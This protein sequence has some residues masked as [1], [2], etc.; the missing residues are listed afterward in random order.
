MEKATTENTHDPLLIAIKLLI[1]ENGG[2]LTYAYELEK[3]WIKFQYPTKINIK[4]RKKDVE[5]ICKNIGKISYRKMA[6]KLKTTKDRVEKKIYYLRKTG[7]L[8]KSDRCI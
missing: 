2:R 5:F 1:R 6:I 7:V 4:W 8:P 3:E